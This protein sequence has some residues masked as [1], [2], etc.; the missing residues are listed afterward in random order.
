MIFESKKTVFCSSC[1]ILIFFVGQHP[2][3]IED[4]HGRYGQRRQ[5]LLR[6]W[7]GRTILMSENASLLKVE[8]KW[9]EHRQSAMRIKYDSLSG[10]GIWKTRCF[11]LD[12]FESGHMSDMVSC[13]ANPG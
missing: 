8:T 12:P 4:H 11:D 1:L 2:L 6:D 7:K 5:Y 10:V 3:K 13:Q 9:Q